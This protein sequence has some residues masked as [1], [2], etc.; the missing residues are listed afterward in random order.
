[1]R[2]HFAGIALAVARRGEKKCL[3]LCDSL[4][5]SISVSAAVKRQDGSD[6]SRLL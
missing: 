2:E 3:V 1:M 4:V 5:V 6:C